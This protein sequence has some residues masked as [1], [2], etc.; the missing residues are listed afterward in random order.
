MAASDPSFVSAEPGP[1]QT[2]RNVYFGSINQNSA[3][4]MDIFQLYAES[5][6]ILS[7]ALHSHRSEGAARVFQGSVASIHLGCCSP[8]PP[9]IALHPFSAFGVFRSFPP[10]FH[11]RCVKRDSRPQVPERQPPPSLCCLR[12]I[13]SASVKLLTSSWLTNTL[14][15]SDKVVIWV[16]AGAFLW[17]SI[18]LPVNWK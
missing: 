8:G 7:V 14:G 5:L 6:K 2:I 10:L 15:K 12:T 3:C 1:F 17:A 4:L 9:F 16:V 11:G 18:S 13:Q